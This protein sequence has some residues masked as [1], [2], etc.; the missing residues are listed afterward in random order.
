MCDAACGDLQAYAKDQESHDPV[1]DLF[2]MCADIADQAV[3]V[4]IKYENELGEPTLFIQVKYPLTSMWLERAAI[5]LIME[6]QIGNSSGTKNSVRQ[7]IIDE[8]KKML[9]NRGRN[10]LDYYPED[11]REDFPDEDYDEKEKLAEAI[12]REFFPEFYK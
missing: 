12:C 1:D 7:R 8:I 4:K 9:I 2:I 6:G 3:G 5:M 11:F 10:A